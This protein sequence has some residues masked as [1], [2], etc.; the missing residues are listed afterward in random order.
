MNMQSLDFND[1]KNK[2]VITN[3]V[4]NGILNRSDIPI[5][6]GASTTSGVLWNTTR[7]RSCV[8]IVKK[9]MSTCSV[10]TDGRISI[11][12][13][14][15]K[16]AALVSIR[17]SIIILRKV[18]GIQCKLKC[19]RFKNVVGS[20]KVFPLDMEKM[21]ER[22]PDLI[23]P[24]FTFPGTYFYYNQIMATNV[25]VSMF[26]TGSI[27]FIGA[28][29]ED[30]IHTVFEHLYHNYLVHIRL[31]TYYNPSIPPPLTEH[32]PKQD[33]ILHDEEINVDDDIL[34]VLRRIKLKIDK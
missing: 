23:P 27:N 3:V 28:R 9:P 5:K 21:R 6:K 32:E 11:M 20:V 14:Q 8:F 34:A 33:E 30:E 25:V 4:L 19:A 17:K 18:M 31:N 29:N 1:Y 15:S 13:A 24:K 10:F 12:G 26:N 7:F 22:W 2:L 16:A